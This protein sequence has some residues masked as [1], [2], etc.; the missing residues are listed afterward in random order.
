MRTCTPDGMHPR[1]YSLLSA[2]AL[3][4]L[5]LIFHIMDVLGTAPTSIQLIVMLLCVLW[6]LVQFYEKICH[7]K[8]LEQ[9]DLVGCPM[10]VVLYTIGAYRWTRVLLMDGA[11]GPSLCPHSGIIAGSTSATFE[12]KACLLPTVKSWAYE[13]DHSRH[14]VHIDDLQLHSWASSVKLCISTMQAMTVSLAKV[15][16]QYVG[17][18][19]SEKKT[20]TANSKELAKQTKAV[21]GLLGGSLEGAPPNLGVDYFAGKPKSQ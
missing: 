15:L 21:V 18:S 5:S 13:P 19:L 14:G 12:A 2:G 8:L 3:E 6:D 9:A 7:C 1:H 16:Q 11:C 20:I 4:A 10:Y 17:C